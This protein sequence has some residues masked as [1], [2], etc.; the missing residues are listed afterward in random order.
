MIIACGDL[1]RISV[2]ILGAELW[3]EKKRGRG[4]GAGHQCD[5]QALSHYRASMLLDLA[6]TDFTLASCYPEPDGEFLNQSESIIGALER[7]GNHSEGRRTTEV[8][9]VTD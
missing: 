2:A 9:S 5:L 8:I 6:K 4:Y 1:L 7:P 3:C